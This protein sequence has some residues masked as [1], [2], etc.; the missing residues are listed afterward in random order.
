MSQKPVSTPCVKPAGFLAESQETGPFEL[1][2]AL[3]ATSH[4]EEAAGAGGAAAVEAAVPSLARVEYRGILLE[5]MNALFRDEVES[6]ADANGYL[7]AWFETRYRNWEDGSWREQKL[8]HK[9]TL[10]LYD[11]MFWCI[12]PKCKEKQ[13]SYVELVAKKPQRPAWF[14]SHWWGEPV[15]DFVRCL[16]EHAR[17]RALPPD[18]A[19]WVCA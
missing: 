16:N 12:K 14:V 19:Y 8:C 4:E 3:D 7:P 18:T 2:R 13:C 9:D 6:R 10:S 11:L 5:Q 1:T 17:V 15:R